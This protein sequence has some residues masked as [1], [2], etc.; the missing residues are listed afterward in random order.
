M[1]GRTSSRMVLVR[2][3]VPALN[4][5]CVVSSPVFRAFVRSIAPAAE[6]ANCARA[7]CVWRRFA[8]AIPR[9][10][11]TMNIRPSSHGIVR[12][13]SF[14]PQLLQVITP[15]T[16]LTQPHWSHARPQTTL[17]HSHCHDRHAFGFA[18]S[19]FAS[20]HRRWHAHTRPSTVR[21]S[22]HAHWSWANHCV[23]ASSERANA[24]AAMPAA[25]IP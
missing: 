23:S 15:Q 8:I 11:T 4:V 10:E 1:T 22:Q 17:R 12:R 2:C 7:A 20:A 25:I 3:S 19:L 18:Q 13:L 16:R 5:R 9:I 24:A 14:T 6:Q 21:P